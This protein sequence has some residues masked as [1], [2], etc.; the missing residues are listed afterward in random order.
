MAGRPRAYL[1]RISCPRCKGHRLRRQPKDLL[2]CA[3]CDCVFNPFAA[4]EGISVDPEAVAARRRADGPT[5]EELA[6]EAEREEAA[7]QSASLAAAEDKA[8]AIGKAAEEK[9]ARLLTEAEGQAAERLAE[10][11]RTAAA[12]LADARRGAA[13]ILAEANGRAEAIRKES[14][15]QSAMA[16]ADRRAYEAAHRTHNPLLAGRAPTLAP[17]QRPPEP[18]P[19]PPERGGF[20]LPFAVTLGAITF[21]LTCVSAAIYYAG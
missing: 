1:P 13:G 10:A 4:D 16:E 6:A 7:R 21:V 18:E 20:W 17:A 14:A 15:R 9:A 2:R 11:D 5:L 19:E 3:N 8:A 12:R